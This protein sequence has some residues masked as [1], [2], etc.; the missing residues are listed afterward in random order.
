MIFF[1]FIGMNAWCLQW[2]EEGDRYPRTGVTEFAYQSPGGPWKLLLCKRNR[3]AKLQSPSL[4]PL[5]TD[6]FIN[7]FVG[8]SDVVSINDL[9]SQQNMGS[10]SK[11]FRDVI[12]CLLSH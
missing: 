1:R 3:C 9:G 10:G 2:S 7:S 5:N 8:K 6:I 4:Q 12:G 11:H